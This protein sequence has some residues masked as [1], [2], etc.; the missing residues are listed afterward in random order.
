[1]VDHAQ[2][3][4][5]KSSPEPG[6]VGMIGSGIAK[7]NSQKLFEGYYVVDLGFRAFTDGIVSNEEAFYSGPIHR[8]VDLG[9]S[10]DS[11]A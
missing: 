9:Y 11:P 5:R 4:F 3:V 10:F 1:M 6:K 8:G 2:C 7:R